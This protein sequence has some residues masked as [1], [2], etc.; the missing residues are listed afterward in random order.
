MNQDFKANF[1]WLLL[2][3]FMAFF[4]V[5][6]FFRG[7]TYYTSGDDVTPLSPAVL[8]NFQPFYLNMKGGEVANIF[9]S[10]VS[11]IVFNIFANPLMFIT[12]RYGE[13]ASYIF[14][15]TLGNFGLLKFIYSFYDL[16]SRGQKGMIAVSFVTLLFFATNVGIGQV[17]N[18]NA[19]MVP[20]FGVFPWMLYLLYL[21][22]KE[23]SMTKAFSYSLIAILLYYIFIA[24]T[25]FIIV[26]IPLAFL[27]ASF[28]GFLALFFRSQTFKVRILRFAQ[29]LAIL[30]VM[31]YPYI[32]SLLRVAAP[33]FASAITSK[34]IQQ[35][36]AYYFVRG[37]AGNLVKTLTLTSTANVASFPQSTYKYLGTAPYYNS[38]LTTIL[39]T[40]VAA[41]LFTPLLL[42]RVKREALFFY[43]GFLSM[44]GWFSAPYFL[45]YYVGLVSHFEL[46]WSLN[47]PEAVFPYPLSVCATL[48][49]AYVS[50]N[51]FLGKGRP[52]VITTISIVVLIIVSLAVNV[53]PVAA[54]SGGGFSLPQPVYKISNIIDSSKT[55]NP[56]VMIAPSSFIYL[57]Y[58]WSAI[59]DGQYVGAGFWQTLL[60]GDTYGYYQSNPPLVG[61]TTLYQANMS[62]PSLYANA[63][64]LLGINYVVY[65]NT[66]V[67]RT[68]TYTGLAAQIP[69]L[70]KENLEQLGETVG[71]NS[72]HVLLN[73]EG[74]TLY[75]YSNATVCYIPSQVV[76]SPAVENLVNNETALSSIYKV[77]N[78]RID[79]GNTAVVSPSQQIHGFLSAVAKVA[80]PYYPYPAGQAAKIIQIS[81]NSP[82]QF[83]CLIDGVTQGILPVIVRYPYNSL[84]D[85]KGVSLK[86][87]STTLLPVAFAPANYGSATMILFNV[88]KGGNYTLKFN[89]N[90]PMNTLHYLYYY[91]EAIDAFA[92]IILTSI[93]IAY[94][95]KTYKRLLIL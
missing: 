31:V 61:F 46:L 5:E 68:L 59:G 32:V 77:L 4:T 25:Y 74:F 67:Q 23:K 34:S 26:N 3:M 91:N 48:L 47:I 2:S 90:P 14:Y 54:Q 60:R 7:H 65:S 50:A 15:F 71:L 27:L 52:K 86:G 45:P 69:T 79:W 64:K 49:I 39:G 28:T 78:L 36:L 16:H 1:I 44:A 22:F 93:V 84:G 11:F 37:Y 70:T 21:S 29:L 41:M 20:I 38:H 76:V 24:N 43:F 87:Q 62:N 6:V 94:K 80:T 17:M 33:S 58:N 8:Y 75:Y 40:A 53:Y 82:E 73:D 10:Y 12:Q 51:I 18:I 85:Y 83:R 88:T 72:Q 57:W 9:S 42:G 13:E 63:L 35:D 56:R 30:L 55:Y 19:S 89:L 66:S 95:I 92:L 81:G